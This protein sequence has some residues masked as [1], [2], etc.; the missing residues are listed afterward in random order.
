MF[1]TDSVAPDQAQ[2]RIAEIYAMFPPQVGVPEPLRLLSASPSLLAIQAQ[3]IDYF[4]NHPNLSFEVLSAIRFLAARFGCY[5]YCANL[6]SGF[7]ARTGVTPDE[8]NALLDDPSNGPFEPREN[9]LIAFVIKT[10]EH[11]DHATNQNLDELRGMGW[12]D[13]DIV[14]AMYQGAGML[15]HSVLYKALRK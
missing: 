4:R 7:L 13:T 1:K 2:G 10:M 6:N 9:A 5:D 8:L 14:D 11:P 15:S 3:V 12:T